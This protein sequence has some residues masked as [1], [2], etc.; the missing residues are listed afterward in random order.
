MRYLFELIQNA[1]DAKYSIAT[2]EKATPMLSFAFSSTELIIESNEDGFRR[3]NVDSIV[4]YWGKLEDRR[5]EGDPP[6]VRRDW[7]SNLCSVS[8]KRFKFSLA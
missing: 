6:L 7:A 4:C 2:E 1:D 5:L 8:R 3:K